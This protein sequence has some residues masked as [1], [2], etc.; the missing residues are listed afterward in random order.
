MPRVNLDG[1][2]GEYR[3]NDLDESGATKYYGFTDRYGNWYILQMTDTTARYARGD[4]N[5]NYTQAWANRT[6]LSYNYY[7]EVF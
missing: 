2:I 5:T 6:S 4:S 1:T 7:H 3:I